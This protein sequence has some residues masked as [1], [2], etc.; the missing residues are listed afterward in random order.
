[1]PNSNAS[2]Y[3]DDQM[4]RAIGALCV[5]S[6]ATVVG[7]MAEAVVDEVSGDLLGFIWCGLRGMV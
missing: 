3:S 4:R 6:E 7:N 5:V 2:S 1:M